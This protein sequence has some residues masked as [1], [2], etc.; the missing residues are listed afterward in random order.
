MAEPIKRIFPETWFF[1]IETVPCVETGR[2][3]Y[4][5]SLTDD[6]SEKFGFQRS[7][8]DDVRELMYQLAGATEIEPRPM[9]KTIMQ[10]IVS[11]SVLIRKGQRGDITFNLFSLSDSDHCDE[12]A[13]IARFLTKLGQARPQVVGFN[14]CGFDLIALFQRAIVHGIEIGGFCVR[15]DKPWDLLPDYFSD[16]NDWNVDLMRVV[17]G[18]GKTTPKLS[19]MARACGI[20]AKVSADGSEVA[21]MWAESRVSEIVN[22]CEEDVL[23][24][25]LLWLRT[26]MVCG[27]I[28]FVD[29]ETETQRFRE[30]LEANVEARSHLSAFLSA[31]QAMGVSA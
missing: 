28:S 25:Y 10:R 16:R 7:S 4:A 20:P 12:S 24:T 3:I 19:E 30:F 15:P 9:L 2:K 6:P 14:S 22:Y 27:A 17:G 26:A 11:I 21:S 13:M 1:D 23:T 29:Y 5:D 31:T 18:F 8:D